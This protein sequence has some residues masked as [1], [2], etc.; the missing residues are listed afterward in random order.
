MGRLKR[1]SCNAWM[2]RCACASFG[3]LAFQLFLDV[4]TK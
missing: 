4:F 2:G 1:F 3:G